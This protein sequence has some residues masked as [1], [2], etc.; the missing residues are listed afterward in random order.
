MFADARRCRPLERGRA[1]RP[2][3]RQRGD[4]VIE[5]MHG[6]EFRQLDGS[7]FTIRA[8][9]AEDMRRLMR[10]CAQRDAASGRCRSSPEPRYRDDRG[11]DERDARCRPR[12]WVASAALQ[13]F[14]ALAAT[15]GLA[16]RHASGSSLARRSRSR[17]APA[18]S[19]LHNLRCG[20]SA[21]SRLPNIRTCAAAWSIWQPAR[22]EEIESL[23]DELNA[24]DDAED[25]I[26]LH[27]ELRYVHRL[28][29]VSPATLHG[30]GR[31]PDAA[32]QPFRIEL[33][34][35]GIL[36]SLS[37]R[38]HRAHAARSPTRSKS[39]SRPPASTSRI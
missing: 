24:A 30:M 17:I 38:R 20:G 4:R 29:P 26:A 28:V 9:N 6:A 39:R 27:G 16:R 35:P 7:G 32:S 10:R 19:R 36:D 22:D 13:L 25:E 37:A 1:A 33:Q 23:A 3:L 21:G 31:Q 15:E 34:R 18:R 11:D 14:Q 5:V 8:G 12:G 2:Q